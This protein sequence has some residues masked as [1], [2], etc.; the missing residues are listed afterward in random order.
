[1]GLNA[2]NPSAAG[3]YEWSQGKPASEALALVSVLPDGATASDEDGQ[4]PSLGD[5][6]GTNARGAISSDGN[7]VIWSE[8]DEQGLYLRDTATGE[9]IKLN[10]AQGNGS[11]E[12]G[13][14]G[15]VLPEPEEGQQLVHFQTA[16]TDGSRVFFT[17]T[18]RLSGQSS[19]E[20]VGEEPPPTCTSS[21]SRASRASR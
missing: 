10:A 7:R 13:E 5:A 17:D 6:G 9:T 4:S 14:G 12:P 11:T 21:N 15:V 1:M 18:A 2:S 3:L 8:A 16:S 19:E 20:P